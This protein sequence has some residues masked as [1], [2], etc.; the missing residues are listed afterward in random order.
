MMTGVPLSS[1]RVRHRFRG[2]IA[3]VGSTSGIR[4][5]VGRWQ[6]SHL[7]SFADA[8][9]VT[10]AGHRVLLAPTDAVADYVLAT[11]AFDEAR[12]EPVQV[13]VAGGTWRIRSPSLTLDLTTGP[14]LALGHLLR[15]IPTGVATHPAWATLTDPVARLLLRGVRTRGTAGGDRREYY[16]ATDARALLAAQGSFDGIPLGTL[17]DVDP[18]CRFGFSSTPRRPSVTDVTT[19]VSLPSS[20]RDGRTVEGSTDGDPADHFR[21]APMRIERTVT[22]DRPI[23]TVFAYLSDFT[24][25]T[26]W[27]PGTVRTT[28]TS[29]DGGVGTVYANTSRFMGRESQLTYTVL[30]RADDAKIVLRGVNKTV[31]ATDTMTFV[32][33]SGGGTTVTYAADFEFS[34]VAK[35]L[36]PVVAPALKKLGDEAEAGMREALAK[37]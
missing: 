30:E 28:L 36:A 15:R 31:T 33:N 22:T 18:P 4:V 13:V 21:G 8:M 10:P 11:Y 23:E 12:V 34:G 35:L 9:V 19:T 7:G 29:G 14:R 27:D 2:Q 1:S 26:Q 5:V 24:T 20:G 37:L 16:G 25:T 3:G 6:D 17:A 32:A